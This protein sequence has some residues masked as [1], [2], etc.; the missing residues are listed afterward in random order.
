MSS[1]RRSS[2][3][4]AACV[5]C[6]GSVFTMQGKKAK[7]CIYTDG[8][9]STS[10]ISSKDY[11]KFLKY[12]RFTCLF[13]VAFPVETGGHITE[14]LLLKNF[15]LKLLKVVFFCFC[16]CFF[17]SNKRLLGEY[18]ILIF[19][20]CMCVFCLTSVWR[21]PHQGMQLILCQHD[22]SYKE[23]SLSTLKLTNL[24]YQLYVAV[25]FKQPTFSQLYESAVKCLYILNQSPKL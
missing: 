24:F 12:G 4:D 22:I 18:E 1:I 23:V 14:Q 17:F 6:Y 11:H 2:K 25:H 8:R 9:C 5:C 3:F 7:R 19:D 20:S 15:G 13:P 10:R 21:L 16:F